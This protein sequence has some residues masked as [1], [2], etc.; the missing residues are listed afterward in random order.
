MG[1]INDD[2]KGDLKNDIKCGINDIKDKIDYIFDSIKQ[3][4][5]VDG[6]DVWPFLTGVNT[7]D[8]R[9]NTPLVISSP[10]TSGPGVRI[11]QVCVCVCVCV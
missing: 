8:P 11:H 6:V 7:T 4:T 2:I 5:W 1:N 3:I 9:L 10:W